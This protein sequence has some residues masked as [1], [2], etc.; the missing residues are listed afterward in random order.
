MASEWVK[1]RVN[2]RKHPKTI[3]M[4]RILMSSRDF[5]TWFCGASNSVNH[6]DDIFV[7]NGVTQFVT[8][9]IVTRVTVSA[10]LEAWGAVNTS[11]RCDLRVPYMQIEDLDGITGIP[12]FG[13]AMAKVGWVSEFAN[14]KTQGLLFPNFSEF[15]TP[16]SERSMAK[17]PAERSAEYRAR[18]KESSDASRSV[19]KRHAASRQ[20]EKSREDIQ[21]QEQSPSNPP[22]LKLAEPPGQDNPPN[23]QVTRPGKRVVAP[24]KHRDE[25]AGFAEFYALYP[26][27]EAR[28]KA[29]AAFGKLTAEQ[30]RKAT[31]AIVEFAASW[32]WQAEPEFIPH[33]TT[34]LNQH[35][36]DDTPPPLARPQPQ[37]PPPR[38][39]RAAA[40]TQALLEDP[41]YDQV[42]QRHNGLA[43]PNGSGRPADAHAALSGL[44]PRPGHDPGDGDSLD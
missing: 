44:R 39:S 10:L 26:R 35:R 9:E 24:A 3:A 15:N 21:D 8:L 33:P 23:L 19:T 41:R 32:K 13:Q 30:Q 25:P 16:D 34:W 28:P 42:A 43:L 7:T 40:I 4:S 1:M 11:V 31:T 38:Q 14:D 12:S 36:F 18:K 37:Q 2:L 17:T 5:V 29:A 20:V 27:K 6:L 22:P